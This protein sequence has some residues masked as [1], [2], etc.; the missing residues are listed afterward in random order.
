VQVKAINAGFEPVF[1]ELDRINLI[2]SAWSIVDRIDATR[3]LLRGYTFLPDARRER[4]FGVARYFRNQMDHLAANIANHSK[5]KTSFPIY[6]RIR[7][8]RAHPDYIEI[9]P[10]GH[11]SILGTT[12]D[13]IGLSETPQNTQFDIPSSPSQQYVAPL[14]DIYLMAFDKELCL[15]DAGIMADDIL[16][17]EYEFDASIEEQLRNHAEEKGVVWGGQV[18]PSHPLTLILK[19][20]FETPQPID[21]ASALTILSR[22]YPSAGVGDVR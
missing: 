7:Y 2:R 6:G 19:A 20:T 4:L 10:A 17:M 15:S 1:D 8:Q 13:L 3:Q 21:N 5:R 9:K 11:S 12:W 16:K 18:M 14:G 22:C